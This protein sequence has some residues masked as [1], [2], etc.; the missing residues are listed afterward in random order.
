MSFKNKLIKINKQAILGFNNN[1]EAFH[2]HNTTKN[3]CVIF[4]TYRG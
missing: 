2:L 4:I 1:Q 3:D